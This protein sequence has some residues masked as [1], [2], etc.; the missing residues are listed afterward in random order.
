MDSLFHHRQL[1]LDT[2]SSLRAQQLLTASVPSEPITARGVTLEQALRQAGTPLIADSVP[3]LIDAAQASLQMLAQP[4]IAVLGE[5]NAGKSSVVASFLSESGQRRLPRGEEAAQ[6]THR[7]VYW[8]PSDWLQNAAQKTSLLQLLAAVHGDRF[9]FLAE[10]R[11]Q[12]AEQ[13]RSG[14][15]RLDLLS[16]PLIA[17]DPALNELG[18][19]L[20]DCPDVQTRDRPS[21]S[22]DSVTRSA[23]PAASQHENPRLAF[24]CDAS[25]ICSALLVVWDRVRIRDG[26]LDDLLA[27]LRQRKAAAP[28]WLLINRIR[29]E[30]G[31]PTRTRTDHDLQRLLSEYQLPSDHCYGAFD[32]DIEARRD[33]P[34]WRELTPPAL[35]ARFAGEDSRTGAG[36]PQFFELRE[37]YEANPTATI[38]ADRFHCHLP[39]KLDL[40]AQQRQQL[41]DQWREL[42]RVLREALVTVDTWREARRRAVAEAQTGLLAFCRR[43]FTD[44]N[45][46]P[47]QLTTPDFSLALK[48]S[49]TRTAPWYVRMPLTVA[50][51]FERAIA[52]AT[53]RMGDVRQWLQRLR[54]PREA[55]SDLTRQLG[56]EL[57]LEG[58]EVASAA[59]LAAEMRGLRWVPA[60]ADPARLEQA[61]QIILSQLLH[62][63]FEHSAEQ[64]DRMTRDVWE[65][66]GIWQKTKAAVLGLFRA[67]GTVAAVGGLVT[68]L[69]DGGAT[70]LISYKLTATIAF[71]AP[72]IK[73]LLVAGGGAAGAYVGFQLRAIE[74]NTLPYLS[75]LFA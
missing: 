13:Y 58:T 35:V 5:L 27:N 62:Q 10:A 71:Y 3:Q 74:L 29:P 18:A 31:Q 43:P 25:R 1:Q 69:V 17:A 37:T 32:F 2:L 4:I 16:V 54:E 57:R 65:H 60:D 48:E 61:W 12:A 49:F 33:Q 7:F 19:A 34:G 44:L 40:T 14:R 21:D 53:R 22:G 26:L 38:P 23:P 73:A 8:V 50:A 28:I 46:Q 47:L 70:L 55:L 51:P 42:R 41:D 15:D 6:G 64:L 20:L 30:R 72:G 68:A 36:F 59:T 9:E 39:K 63:R 11:E 66:L 56:Q 52:W 24:L 75:R 45:E 67:L